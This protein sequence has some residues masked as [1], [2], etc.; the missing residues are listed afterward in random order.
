MEFRP[1]IDIHNGRVK[2]IVGASLKDSG[3]YAKENF[4][5]G[6]DSSY[7]AGMFQ[8]DGLKGGH[9]IML[10]PP[11]SPYYEETVKMAKLAFSSYPGF[12]QAGGGINDKN[13]LEYL[14]AGALSVIVS[15]FAVRSGNIC[16]DH[17]DALKSVCGAGKIVLDLSCKKRDGR[18]YVVTDRWQRFSDVEVCEKTLTDL[19]KY[20]G[21]YL[22]HAADVEGKMGGVD[23]DLLR[24][25]GSYEGIGVTY[26]GG[27]RSMDDL[28][29]IKALGNNRINVTVGSALDIY[30]GELSYNE[31]VDFCKN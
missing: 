30:G 9:V 8:K 19:E 10:N 31:I 17:L 1:C 16:Y 20:A 29:L 25:L 14:R 15:S 4:V 23:E 12:L 22:I 26:A 11:E 24:I 7:Y 5:S 2:Q 28:R 6:K 21:E 18:Y 13:A 3:D 27:V